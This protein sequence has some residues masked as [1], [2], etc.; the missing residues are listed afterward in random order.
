MIPKDDG[1]VKVYQKFWKDELY[2]E[3]RYAPPLLI[4]ADLLLTNDPRCQETAMM[5]YEK[6]L[7]DEFERN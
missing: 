5:I 3:N 6:N 1:V 7:K 2:E 4:Y